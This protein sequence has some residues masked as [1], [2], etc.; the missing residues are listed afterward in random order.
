M[1]PPLT[2][3]GQVTYAP[4]NPKPTV[5]QMAQDVAA[6]LVWTAEPDLMERRQYGWAVVIFLLF[7]TILGYRAY[8]QLW[9]ETKRPLR[10]P[11]PLEPQNQARARRSKAKAGGAG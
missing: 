7:G 5:D 4:G 6:F 8:H 9:H 11:A 10:E 2:T 1:P 3:D